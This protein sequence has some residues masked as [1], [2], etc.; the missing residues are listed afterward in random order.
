MGLSSYY[1]SLKSVITHSLVQIFPH[2][3]TVSFSLHVCS[4]SLPCI[5]PINVINTEA[6]ITGRVFTIY[7]FGVKYIFLEN[8]NYV[9]LV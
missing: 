4:V 3:I 6:N 9:K 2:E 8:F 5:E 1:N 7:I